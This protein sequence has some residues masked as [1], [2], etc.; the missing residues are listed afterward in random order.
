[1]KTSSV[2]QQFAW[3]FTRADESV[4]LQIH[5]KGSAFRLVINGPG[6]AQ[7]SHEFDTMTSMM[8][9]VKN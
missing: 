3:L 5:E 2:L 7:A 6:A 9:F 1:M 8:I 4:R